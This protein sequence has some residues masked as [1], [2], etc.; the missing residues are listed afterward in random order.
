MVELTP[1][2]PPD[3]LFH[4]QIKV[5]ETIWTS[6]F[7]PKAAKRRHYNGSVSVHLSVYDIVDFANLNRSPRLINQINQL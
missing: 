6:Q 3:R 1:H 5:M 7:L 2:L 4:L